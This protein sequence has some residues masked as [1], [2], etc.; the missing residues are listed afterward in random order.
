MLAQVYLSYVSLHINKF[1]RPTHIQHT[2]S[3]CV[4]I[5]KDLILYYLYYIYIV[6]LTHTRTQKSYIIVY[7]CWF[8]YFI[9]S[10][11]ICV[12]IYNLLCGRLICAHTYIYLFYSKLHSKCFNLTFKIILLYMLDLYMHELC[13]TTA[14]R[15]YMSYIK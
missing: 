9:I 15:F 8:S 3:C 2:S 6:L 10:V 1:D 4:Y 5:R 7:T 11:F 14:V 13:T 12:V